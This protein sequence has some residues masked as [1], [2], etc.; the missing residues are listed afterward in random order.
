MSYVERTLWLH[1]EGVSD[2]RFIVTAMYPGISTNAEATGWPN[3]SEDV[4]SW[5]GVVL[6]LF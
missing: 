6:P 4:F 1:Q 5:D 2:T 3:D